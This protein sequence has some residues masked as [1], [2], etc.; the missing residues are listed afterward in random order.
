MSNE[1]TLFGGRYEMPAMPSDFQDNITD[2]LAG[3][4]G[5]GKRISIRGGAFREIVNGKEV[6]VSEERYINVVML[7]AAPV[8]RQ[9]YAGS[10]DSDA[11]AVPPTCWSADTETPDP[12]V[13]E[14]QRQATRCADC[15]KNVKGSGQGDSRACRFSQRVAVALEGKIAEGEVYQLSVPATSLFGDGTKDQMPLQT[16]ARYLKSHNTHAISVITKM[17]FD[18]EASTPKL[19][20]S[21]VRPLNAEELKTAIELK[22]SPEATNA[23]TMTVAETDKV[24]A[25]TKK[26]DPVKEEDT[27]QDVFEEET[28]TGKSET[29]A[30]PE[31]EETVEEPKKV[32][33]KKREADAPVDL[34]SILDG[35]DD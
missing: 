18:V 13:P 22:D 26:P 27:P 14:E 11:K 7:N 23:I 34:D 8:S 31:K 6:N 24:E 12:K 16:Y 15:P 1:M 2:T 28:P 10:Y 20:F 19:F 30:A 21:P 32:E 9:Y 29:T 5:G 4:G 3:S 17:R 25:P 35:W 33:S